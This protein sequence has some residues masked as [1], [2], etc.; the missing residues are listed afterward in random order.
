PRR[1]THGPRLP[2][3]RS[4]TPKSSIGALPR[5]RS[6]TPVAPRCACAPI[7]ERLNAS[8]SSTQQTWPTCVAERALG[9]APIDDFE[10]A[11]HDA[12]R[13]RTCFSP[14]ALGAEPLFFRQG[15]N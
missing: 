9:S 14:M 7:V 2:A 12:G 8:P 5:A 11:A 15:L 3:S 1:D 10:F 6:A 4:P 13:P